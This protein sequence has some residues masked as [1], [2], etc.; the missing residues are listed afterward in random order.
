MWEDLYAELMNKIRWAISST[1]APHSNMPYRESQACARPFARIIVD[2][3]K[4]QSEAPDF[5]ISAYIDQQTS[6]K[7]LDT[8]EV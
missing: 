5:S 1:V 3:L 4:L 7:H 8:I 2:G 6:S